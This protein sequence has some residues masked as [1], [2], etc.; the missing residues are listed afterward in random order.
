MQ[1]P[2]ERLRLNTVDLKQLELDLVEGIRVSLR[3]ADGHL[4]ASDTE[5]VR[6]LLHL[7]LAN[8]KLLTTLIKNRS[9]NATDNLE[10]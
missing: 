2:T 9:N 4:S 3:L 10:S 8:A 1:N 7:S 5:T 6:T